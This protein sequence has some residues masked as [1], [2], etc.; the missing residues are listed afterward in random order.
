MESTG[1]P[2]PERG[3]GGGGG[4]ESGEAND[5]GEPSERV[6]VSLESSTNP[7]GC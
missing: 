5:A 7:G 4:E 1:L 6:P 3:R 2:E